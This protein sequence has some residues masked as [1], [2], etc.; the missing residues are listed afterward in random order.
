VNRKCCVN[1]RER[2]RERERGGGESHAEK[3]VK[4]FLHWGEKA[5]SLG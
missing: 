5:H 1:E 4:G 2:E 3:G